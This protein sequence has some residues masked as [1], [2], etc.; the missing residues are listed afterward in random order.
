[1][2]GEKERGRSAMVEEGEREGEN[3]MTSFWRSGTNKEVRMES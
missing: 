1:M 2:G 3:I